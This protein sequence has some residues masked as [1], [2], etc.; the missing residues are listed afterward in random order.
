MTQNW[1]GIEHRKNSSDHDNLTRLVVL[2]E[3]HVANF[4]KH[5]NDFRVHLLDDKR[6]FDILFKAYWAGMGVISMAILIVKLLK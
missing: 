6:N 2:L 1:D 5:Q 3:A 4:D